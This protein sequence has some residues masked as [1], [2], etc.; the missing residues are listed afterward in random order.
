MDLGLG[1]ASQTNTALTAQT[2]FR[3]AVPRREPAEQSNGAGNHLSIALVA[4]TPATSTPIH[5]AILDSTEQL[6]PGRCTSTILP[7]P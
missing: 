7:P 5:P 2:I 4:L 1:H 3:A 6:L